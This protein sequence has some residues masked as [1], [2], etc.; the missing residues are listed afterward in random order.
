MKPERPRIDPSV[1]EFVAGHCFDPANF[2]IRGVSMCRLNR[3]MAQK[4]GEGDEVEDLSSRM[5]LGR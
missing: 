1:L 5:I 4:C 2:F 3:E